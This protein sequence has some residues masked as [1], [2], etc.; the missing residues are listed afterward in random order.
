MKR[1]TFLSTSAAAGLAACAWGA[2]AEELKA[3]DIPK[4]T[5]G[6][7]G[8]RLTIIGQAGGRFPMCG[9]EDA[10]AITLRAYELGI[11]YFDCARVY[12][13]GRSEE[14]YGA[15]LPP[16]RKHIFMTTKSGLRTRAGAEGDLE[17]SLRAMKT[18]YVDLWQI[19]MVNTLEEVEQIFAPGGA[20]E[21][22]EAAKKAGKCRFIGFTGHHDPMVHLEMLKRYEKFDSVLMPLNPADPAYVSFEKQVLPVAVERGMGIQGMKSTANSKLLHTIPIRDCLT[23]VLSLPISCLAVGCT[24]IGQIEDDVRIVQAFKPLDEAAMANIREKAAP[25]MGPQLE[26]W[27][28][29]KETG[30]ASTYRDGCFSGACSE[31]IWEG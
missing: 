12:W 17:K 5:F 27:K 20:M 18:D 26:N 16:F 1:R 10:K 19:H 24:T 4:R 21:A 31:G 11:N 13:D 14:V 15:V 2:R 9:F 8:D 28:I 7:T 23:Y 6:K 3:G 25:F 22:F 29:N 30:K